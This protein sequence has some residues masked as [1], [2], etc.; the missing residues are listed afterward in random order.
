MKKAG[1]KIKK[2]GIIFLLSAIVIT[3]CGCSKF[4]TASGL[5]HT[6]SEYSTETSEESVTSIQE[7]S[8]E[9]VT[10]RQESSKESETS[11]DYTPENSSYYEPESSYEYDTSEISNSG[12]KHYEKALASIYHED[13][14]ND[15]DT[16]ELFYT[17]VKNE[18]DLFKADG[19]DT[20]WY[21][22]NFAQK[23]TVGIGI[24]DKSYLDKY[25]AE[26]VNGSNTAYTEMYYGFKAEII[27]GRTLSVK[28]YTNLSGVEYIDLKIQS[29]RPDIISPD[30]TVD[31]DKGTLTADLYDES[32]INGCYAITGTY[33]YKG[34]T[35]TCNL[36]LYVN[37][38][39]NDPSDYHFYIC[40]NDGHQ[41]KD[42]DTPIDFYKKANEVLAQSDVTPE[43]SL[44]LNIAYP[45]QALDYE[46]PVYDTPNWITKS[47]EIVADYKNASKAFKATLLHDWIVANLA[48]DNYKIEYLDG[49]S[50]YVGHCDTD[51]FYPS[52][53]HVGVCFDFANIYMIM[54]RAQDIPC[55]TC[56]NEQEN[57]VWN[58]VYIDGQ[59]AEVDTTFDIIYHVYTEDINKRVSK[60]DLLYDYYFNYPKHEAHDFANSVNKCL[61]L[62]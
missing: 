48:Y 34:K 18:R 35:S 3:S 55:V 2:A 58:L 1:N 36:Y 45:Y 54:C 62:Y 15:P 30:Y 59:W 27:N 53:S 26:Y 20:I 13:M 49:K 5:L 47:N 41:S 6:E 46:N 16:F 17:N 50:R 37:C 10:S 22:F 25:N 12:K 14:D 19:K 33:E 56:E 42:I 60:N 40:E 51:A 44:N 28:N 23:G 11:Y 24:S 9:S 7:S 43:N 8:K 32:F 61:Y 4:L 21:F 29:E 57:H 31:Y 39:S 52:K 38:K